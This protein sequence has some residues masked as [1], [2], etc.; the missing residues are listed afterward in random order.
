MSK[1]FIFRPTVDSEKISMEH[2]WEYWSGVG[3]LLYLVKHLHPDLANMS[4]ELSKTND[5]ANPVAYNELLYVIK[6]VLDT[7]N[8]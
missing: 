6:Y 5:G 4:R 1:F 8:L 2:Q 3:M 7:K